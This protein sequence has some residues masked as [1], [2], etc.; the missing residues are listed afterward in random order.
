MSRFTFT[1]PSE[2]H[3][4]EDDDRVHDYTTIIVKMIITTVDDV[5]VS[6]LTS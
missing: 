5:V 3:A 1:F 6:Q 2:R 4:D